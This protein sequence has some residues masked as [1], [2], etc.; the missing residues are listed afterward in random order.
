L[1]QPL[2]ELL[3]VGCMCVGSALE[4]LPRDI[5][6]FLHEQFVQGIVVDEPVMFVGDEAG[7]IIDGLGGIVDPALLEGRVVRVR[8]ILRAQADEAGDGLRPRRGE[9]PA[10]ALGREVG[11]G[12]AWPRPRGAEPLAGVRDL[13][14]ALH[15]SVVVSIRGARVG[16][17]RRAS[18]V[19][20]GLLFRHA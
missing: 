12:V 8:C 2:Q 17:P 13:G 15:I 7:G 10:R 19:F 3:T 16:D 18:E 11:L 20:E 5:A 6:T 9:F 4:S 14:L 1:L